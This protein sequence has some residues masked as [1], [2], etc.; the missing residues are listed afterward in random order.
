M[1]SWFLLVPALVS[2]LV[3]RL[4]FSFFCS[5]DFAAVRQDQLTYAA[6]RPQKPLNSPLSESR[7]LLGNMD[8]CC[9]GSMLV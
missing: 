5:S 7:P 6:Q 2:P 9:L 3:S 4:V 1:I 8:S